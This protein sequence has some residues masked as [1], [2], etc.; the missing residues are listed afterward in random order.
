M[1]ED[2]FAFEITNTRTNFFILGVFLL[3]WSINGF[4]IGGNLFKMGLLMLG[5]GLILATS[6]TLPTYRKFINFSLLSLSFLLIYWFIAIVRN[7]KTF[8]ASIFTFDVI[9][10][11]LLL[12][13]YSIAS[14]LK[15]FKQA[16]PK[17]VLLISLLA[18]IGG[19]M[20][21]KFQSQLLLNSVGGNSRSAV[22]DGDESGINAI[23]IA[24][25]NAIVF[26]ILYYFVVYYNLKKWM[27]GIVFLSLFSVIFVILTTQSRGALIYIILILVFK[28]F[29][30]LLS[31]RNLFKS[32]ILLFFGVLIFLITLSFFPAMQEKV[33]GTLKRFETLIEISENVEAD[34]S[35]NERALLIQDFFGNIGDVI[36]LGKEEYE[37]YPHN[38]FIEI[39]MRWGLFFG[40][41]L[42]IFSLY[43]FLK[44]LLIFLKRI[45]TH[46]IVNLIAFLFV[47]SFLQSLSSMSLEMNRMFWLGLGFLAAIPQKYNNTVNK[48]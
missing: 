18:I 48:V 6:F 45:N 28:N 24:Y 34:Q 43:N 15:Y 14:N 37:P 30:K 10:F 46:S 3:V 27:K 22:E 4:F 39:I 20:F 42:I 29:K 17:I 25:T 32:L 7:Q 36:L 5:F 26:F 13:G 19:V 31:I 16:S 33:E 1:S 40:M 21:V 8:T 2:K 41:P 44:S 12:S 35:S 23:G 9:C 47:F 38:Q 11:L